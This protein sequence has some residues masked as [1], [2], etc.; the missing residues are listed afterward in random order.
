MTANATTH[1]PYCAS[2]SS[3]HQGSVLKISVKINHLTWDT[4][5]LYWTKDTHNFLDIPFPLFPRDSW[6]ALQGY[7]DYL[8]MARTVLMVRTIQYT[9]TRTQ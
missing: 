3:M 8:F 6:G 7:L 5:E 9:R 2:L 4:K 1:L